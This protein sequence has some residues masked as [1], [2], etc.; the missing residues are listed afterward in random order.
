MLS[1]ELLESYVTRDVLIQALERHLIALNKKVNKPNIDELDKLIALAHIRRVD[2]LLIEL[3]ND[4][5]IKGKDLR[6]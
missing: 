4:G 6:V 2:E 3:C 5:S 1:K